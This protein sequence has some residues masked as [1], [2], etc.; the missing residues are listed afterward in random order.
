MD[1]V[2]F[3]DSLREIST[4]FDFHNYS[5]FLPVDAVLRC[6]ECHMKFGY[7]RPGSSVDTCFCRSCFNN[8][9]SFPN[10]PTDSIHKFSVFHPVSCITCHLPFGYI[11]EAEDLKQ[12]DF[13][14]EYCFD[15]RP[16]DLPILKLQGYPEFIVSSFID[17]Y[18]GI[19][20]YTWVPTISQA[21]FPLT[22]IFKDD[23]YTIA[24]IGACFYVIQEETDLLEIL[25]IHNVLDENGRFIL[26]V[27]KTAGS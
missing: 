12:C 19:F 26:P 25:I 1:V 7:S 14:C 5:S 8:H 22:I 16:E 10:I 13:V 4:K 27:P 11:S 9:R 18:P 20:R 21:Y 3:I 2:A 24:H 23:N 6:D 17:Y 15:Q